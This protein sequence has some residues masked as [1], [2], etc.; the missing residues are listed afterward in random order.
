[1]A[2]LRSALG[3]DAPFAA[4][5]EHIRCDGVEHLRAELARVEGLGGEG[6]M[7]RQP[8]SAYVKSRSSTL[9]KVKT[10]F[11]AEA[12][13][14][15]Y[16]GGAGRHKGRVGALNVV[17]PG[18]VAFAVGTGLTDRQRENPP[19]VGSVITY[20]YQEL[21]DDGVPRFPT[22]VAVRHDYQWPADGGGQPAL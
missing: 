17:T 1:M 13:V 20:R 21:T 14:E 7:L 10:F 3:D 6:L 4:A 22:F 9:L 18:G 5:V 19:A 8:G 12:R 2:W 16:K 15:S 11:D